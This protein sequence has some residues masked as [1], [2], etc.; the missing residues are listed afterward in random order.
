MILDN[1]IIFTES[2]WVPM[3]CFNDWKVFT[4][5]NWSLVWS[6]K[7]NK[8]L[9]LIIGLHFKR[10]F[11]YTLLFFVLIDLYMS[12]SAFLSHKKRPFLLYDF[13]ENKLCRTQIVQDNGTTTSRRLYVSGDSGPWIIIFVS[14]TPKTKPTLNSKLQ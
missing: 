10:A 9:F 4:W 8:Y 5:I 13:L 3:F 14:S 6:I 11:L 7:S 2:W 1:A 12:K